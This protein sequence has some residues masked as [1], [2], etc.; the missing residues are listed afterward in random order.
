MRSQ[1]LGYQLES[2]EYGQPKIKGYTKGYLGASSP[3]RKRIR[4]YTREQGLDGADRR[5]SDAR[6]QG[7]LSTWS[8]IVRILAF[9]VVTQ[10]E[11]SP[12]PSLQHLCKEPRDRSRKRLPRIEA[13]GLKHDAV[14]IAIGTED[15]L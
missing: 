11:V 15:W 1:R 3:R 10:L 12:G 9:I 6:S 14:G 13:V 2:G 7:L 4:D 5:A 8:V